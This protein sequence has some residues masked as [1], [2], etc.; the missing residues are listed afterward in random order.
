M[1]L[2]TEKHT[3]LFTLFHKGETYPVQTYPNEYYSLMTLIS[4]RLTIPG[5]GLCCGMGS[6]GT[7]IVQISNKYSAV[8]RQVLSCGV[9][10]NDD[11]ANTQIIIP[12]VIY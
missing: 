10:I 3:I 7:C 1:S 11:L 12:D 2:H 8:K 9:S 6:C 4:D 5:F